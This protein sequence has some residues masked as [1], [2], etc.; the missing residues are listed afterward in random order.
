MP[1]VAAIGK[2]HNA[3]A[4]DFGLK[5]RVHESLEAPFNQREGGARAFQA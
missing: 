5:M 4:A 1:R 2:F 3:E